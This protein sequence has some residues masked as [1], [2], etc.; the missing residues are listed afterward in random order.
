MPVHSLLVFDRKGRTLFTKR[1]VKKDKDE[2]DDAEQLKDKSKLV[3]G[4]LFSLRE[5]VTSLTP[6][7]ARNEGGILS[8]QTGATT[9]YSMETRGLRF[10]LFMTTNSDGSDAKSIRNA[11]SYIY[12][13]LWINSVTRSPLYNPT[14]PNVAAT[15]FE[16]NLE[17]FLSSQSWYR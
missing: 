3:F 14:A 10:A 8:V 12:N 1:F 7:D 15:S 11:L 6:E 5:V 17:S 4:M 2:E 9:L 13:N 16:Q